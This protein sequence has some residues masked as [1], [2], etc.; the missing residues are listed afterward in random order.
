MG[1]RAVG[2]AAPGERVIE[3]RFAIDA[4]GP[5]VPPAAVVGHVEARIATACHRSNH[6]RSTVQAREVDAE[7]M[8]LAG[9]CCGRDVSAPLAYRRRRFERRGRL[10][11]QRQTHKS[12]PFVVASCWASGTSPSQ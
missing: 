11:P 1:T 9:R 8:R 7:M 12:R 5:E 4:T 6:G 10:L 2:D 3:L